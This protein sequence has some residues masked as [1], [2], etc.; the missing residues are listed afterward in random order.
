[1][2]KIAITIT[3]ERLR[4][5][6]MLEEVSPQKLF[7]GLNAMPGNFAD[8]PRHN[9]GG[10]AARPLDRPPGMGLANACETQER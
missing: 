4:A 9:R 8:V 10:K 6:G 3:L 2:P 5:I 1:M 7:P